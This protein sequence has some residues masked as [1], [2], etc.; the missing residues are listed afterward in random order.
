MERHATLNGTPRDAQWNPTRRSTRCRPFHK[1]ADVS[2]PG[3]TRSH[4]RKTV[5]SGASLAAETGL[6]RDKEEPAAHNA[7]RF[8][9]RPQVC[10]PA[11]QVLQNQRPSRG[12]LESVNAARTSACATARQNAHLQP[13]MVKPR[14]APRPGRLRFGQPAPDWL[15]GTRD[16]A[17]ENA[18]G[19]LWRR[20]QIPTPPR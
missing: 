4:E 1:Y 3:K 8:A 16:E 6:S 14:R 9:N 12:F 20:R 2:S 18:P 17:L 10:Q 19:P 15:P 13:L 11:P 7:G 5:P